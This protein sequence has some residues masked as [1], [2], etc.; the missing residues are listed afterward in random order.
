MIQLPGSGDST[1]FSI[2]PQNDTTMKNLDYTET[3]LEYNINVWEINPETGAGIRVTSRTEEVI[4]FKDALNVLHSLIDQ[5]DDTHVIRVELFI[6]DTPLLLESFNITT[7]DI[8]V[9]SWALAAFL[10]CTD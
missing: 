3:H 5:V 10:E 4:E 1:P 9:P 7:R 8:M 2:H 6:R